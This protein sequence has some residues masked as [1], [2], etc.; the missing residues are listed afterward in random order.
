MM[1]QIIRAG[2]TDRDKN[3]IYYLVTSSWVK[4]Q[5]ET[6]CSVTGRALLCY[7]FFLL[8][9]TAE[10]ASGSLIRYNCVICSVWADWSPAAKTHWVKWGEIKHSVCSKNRFVL[11]YLH[12]NLRHL[13]SCTH[14]SSSP[15]A[16][17]V[18]SAKH[19]QPGD[20]SSSENILSF[21]L[22]VALTAP[23]SELEHLTVNWVTLQIKSRFHTDA[24]SETKS[25]R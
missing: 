20:M 1:T 24:N 16:H 12:N 8:Q 23:Q 5:C 3:T 7:N 9:V 17:P 18:S 2:N 6:R 4:Y 11:L 10:G 19:R 25:Y 13:M 22:L 14:S 15:E 21:F